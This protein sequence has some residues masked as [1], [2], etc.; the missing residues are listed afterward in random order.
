MQSLRKKRYMIRVILAF[1]RSLVVRV[2]SKTTLTT[3]TRIRFHLQRAQSARE[4]SK[5]TT[6]G[7]GLRILQSRRKLLTTTSC[8]KRGAKICTL[9]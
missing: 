1:K 7:R 4:A 6:R 9:F 3:P 2:L 8:Q 5:R